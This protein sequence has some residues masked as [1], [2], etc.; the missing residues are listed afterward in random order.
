MPKVKKRLSANVFERH[1]KAQQWCLKNNIRV[2]AHALLNGKFWLVY[3]NDGIKKSSKTEYTREEIPQ[4]QWD[5]Y[6]YIYEKRRN[7]AKEGH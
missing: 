6:L 3:E 4:K 2:Y 7:L 5:F 1:Y